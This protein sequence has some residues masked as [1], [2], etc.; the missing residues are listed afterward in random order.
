LLQAAIHVNQ[1]SGFTVTGSDR[2]DPSLLVMEKMLHRHSTG[3]PLAPAAGNTRNLATA[4]A[5]N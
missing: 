5:V 3:P 4:T 1:K 2:K